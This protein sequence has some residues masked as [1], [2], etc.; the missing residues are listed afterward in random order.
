MLAAFSNRVIET[1]G[2]DPGV[3]RFDG[4]QPEYCGE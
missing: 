1:T 4:L 3:D 2:I